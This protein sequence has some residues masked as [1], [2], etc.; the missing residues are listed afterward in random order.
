MKNIFLTG[1][2]MMLLL[3]TYKKDLDIPAD[4]LQADHKNDVLATRPM[5]S[6]CQ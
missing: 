1:A 4:G 5:A 3:F 2:V 6:Y